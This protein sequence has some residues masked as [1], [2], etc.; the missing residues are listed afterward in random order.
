MVRS[1]ERG[2]ALVLGTRTASD[3]RNIQCTVLCLEEVCGGV[4]PERNN[5]EK[6]LD[7]IYL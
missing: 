2:V 6:H 3:E 7:S 4:D 5:V 1:P